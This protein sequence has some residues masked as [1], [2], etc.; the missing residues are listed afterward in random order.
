[1]YLSERLIVI[2]GVSEFGATLIQIQYNKSKKS[3]YGISCD[4]LILSVV[5]GLAS[6]VS[7]LYY[8]MSPRIWLEY[9]GRYPRYPT[10]QISSGIFVLE[11]LMWVAYCGVLWQIFVT[12]R[13]TMH[14][15]QGFSGLCRSILVAMGILLIVVEQEL[16]FLLDLIDSIWFVSKFAA[17]VRF[18]PQCIINWSGDCVVGYGDQWL[19]FQWLAWTLLVV[20]KYRMPWEI[21]WHDVPI[22][23]P[24]WPYIICSVF[25]LSVLTVQRFMY[26][27][28][29]VTL[30]FRNKGCDID[31]V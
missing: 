28:N 23:V 1:M 14:I 10:V 5:A 31:I 11:V 12:Y 13:Q 4:F 20:G 6:I 24:P 30:P 22:N 2:S 27:G 17:A 18:V 19:S 16:D 8:Q 26:K 3:V 7:T 29:M 25:W 21:L 15:F 9:S